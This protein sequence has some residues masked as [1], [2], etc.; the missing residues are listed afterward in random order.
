MFIKIG[1]TN[2]F[3]LDAKK[4]STRE[5]FDEIFMRMNRTS[6]TDQERR[7]METEI[8]KQKKA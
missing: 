6:I 7:E 3:V 8:R 5:I 2:F 4:K 1:D